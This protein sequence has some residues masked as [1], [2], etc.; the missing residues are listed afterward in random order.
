MHTAHSPEVMRLM[1][2]RGRVDPVI[3][4]TTMAAAYA[5]LASWTSI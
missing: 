5:R 2:G 3:I 4:I 1:F